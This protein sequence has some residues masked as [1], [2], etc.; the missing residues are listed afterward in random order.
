MW[1]D[2]KEEEGRKTGFKGMQEHPAPL[3]APALL[4]AKK[5]TLRRKGVFLNI[6]G[7]VWTF[8]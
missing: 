7:L 2:K 3:L 8:L 1:E 4:H 5:G 6:I